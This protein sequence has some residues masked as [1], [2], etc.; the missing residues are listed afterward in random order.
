VKNLSERILSGYGWAGGGVGAATACFW[1]VREYLDKGQAS[2]LYLPVVIACAI[3]FGFGPAVAGALL[4]FLCW[5][6]F[7]LPPFGTFVVADPKDWL[8]LIVFL[9]A[10]VSTS[11]LAA[12]ARAQTEQARA[13]EAEVETLLQASEVV[14]REVGAVQLLAALTEQLQTLC[15]ATICVVFQASS[16]GTALRPIGEG[17]ISESAQKMAETVFGQDQVI[18][19]GPNDRLWAKAWRETALSTLES[20]SQGIYVPLHAAGSRVGV[21]HVGPSRDGRPFSSA[22]Q[23]LI[24]TLAN[25]AAT[26][27]A[28]EALAQE[29]AQAA[30]LREADLLKDSLLSLV[31]HELRTP[32]AAIKASATGLLQPDAHWDDSER[33]ETLQA[34]NHEADHLTALV[35]NLLDLSRLE[36]GAWIP[37]KDWCDISDVVGS[38][39]DRLPTAD[40]ARVRVEMPSELPLIQA[41][42]TQIALTLENLLMNAV[43]YSPRDS[44]ILLSALLDPSH[45][46]GL[47][48][49]IRDYGSGIVPGEEKQIF[50]RF[51][52][53]S[54][55]RDSAIHGTGLGLALCHAI[56]QAHDGRL[57]AANPSPYEPSGAVFSVTL[58]GE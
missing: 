58:P 43:K 8:S 2:L 49:R 48:I 30:A 3:R 9:I 53:G 29:A 32:L 13:R 45:P 17:T 27:I 57:W 52:R 14:T 16:S 21:L 26:V 6:F 18:G 11:Q 28:R 38:V 35:G 33:L 40:A 4:S 44:P 25:H 50:E 10:A 5:N 24:L 12:Q 56:V 55:H 42:Y 15:Q 22:E 41:D 54:R 47:C 31:S 19:F 46:G 20:E 7:F 23:R 51:F 1:L 37:N 36:A 39:L 34:I